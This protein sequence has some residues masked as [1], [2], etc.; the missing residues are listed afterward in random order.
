MTSKTKQTLKK[1]ETYNQAYVWIWLPN[2]TSPVIA[3]L[4]TQDGTILE[5]NY[6]KS[7]LERENKI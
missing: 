5:F 6:G 4:L 7:Y 1:S 2:E 3:G